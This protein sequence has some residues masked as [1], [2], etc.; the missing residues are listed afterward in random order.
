MR[1][2]KIKTQATVDALMAAIYYRYLRH[3]YYVDGY[4]PW[5]LL[6]CLAIVVLPI[7]S[8]DYLVQLGVMAANAATTYAIICAATP[9]AVP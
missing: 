9:W 5:L 2:S 3:G 8:D 7:K 4:L 6:P 1:K